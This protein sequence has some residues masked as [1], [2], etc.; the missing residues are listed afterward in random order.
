MSAISSSTTT[1]SSATASISRLASK[2][3]P[4]PAWLGTQFIRHD[5]ARVEAEAAALRAAGLP[6][7]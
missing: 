1:I 2:A 6:S 3:L 5:T 7:G 4:S